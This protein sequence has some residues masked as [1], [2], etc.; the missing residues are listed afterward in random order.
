M[1]RIATLIILIALQAPAFADNSTCQ[2]TEDGVL[3]ERQAVAKLI[4]T[5]INFGRA[6]SVNATSFDD[7]A[8]LL[9]NS[10]ESKKKANKPPRTFRAKAI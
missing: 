3:L 9:L 5:K 1:Y 6:T 8:E 2:K 4:Q 7:N 10:F